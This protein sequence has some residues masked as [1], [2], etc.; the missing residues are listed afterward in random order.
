[1]CGISCSKSFLDS[2]DK[3]FG[4]VIVSVGGLDDS[5][6]PCGGNGILVVSCCDERHF[7]VHDAA[8]F[9]ELGDFSSLKGGEQL[10]E[11]ISEK[12]SVPELLLLSI[13]CCRDG[14]F[15]VERDCDLMLLN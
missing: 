7:L 10:E 12:E 8:P 9:A 3:L 4:G 13:S 2:C 11:E 1:M 6:V 15:S 14:F 5:L